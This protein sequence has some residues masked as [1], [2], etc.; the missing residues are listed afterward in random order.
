MYNLFRVAFRSWL[1]EDSSH[2]LLYYFSYLMEP[3]ERDIPNAAQRSLIRG[4]WC[5]KMD[6]LDMHSQRGSVCINSN[7]QTKFSLMNKWSFHTEWSFHGGLSTQVLWYFSKFVC[8]H[9][10]LCYSEWGFCGWHC[11]SVSEWM[12]S[13]D[14]N[15]SMARV[16]FVIWLHCTAW[17]YIPNLSSL[18]IWNSL[19]IY[20]SVYYAYFGHFGEQHTCSWHICW[21]RSSD[22]V[23]FYIYSTGGLAA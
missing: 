20:F 10:L 19:D 13:N 3:S 6:V 1:P 5:A 9:R 21:S 11:W 8:F 14:G 4:G 23:V 16:N 17:K 2:P 7:G 15:F 12:G 22:N 18:N